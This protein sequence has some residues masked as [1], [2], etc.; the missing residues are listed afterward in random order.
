MFSFALVVLVGYRCIYISMYTHRHS[1]K[2]VLYIYTHMYSFIHVFLYAFTLACVLSWIGI[3]VDVYTCIYINVYI[4][5]YISVHVYIYIC[6]R[7]HI[8]VTGGCYHEVAYALFGGVG[9][10]GPLLQKSP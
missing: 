5:I 8:V 1:D 4:Y 6:T 9:V 10:Y 2:Y 7:V 3:R